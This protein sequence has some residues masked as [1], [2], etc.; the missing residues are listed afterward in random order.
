MIKL[1][2]RTIIMSLENKVWFSFLFFFFPDGNRE[3]F[4]RILK[5]FVLFFSKKITYM[6]I[7]EKN[8]DPMSLKKAVK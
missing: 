2:I 7:K 5:L 1:K 6:G 8:Q 3:Q 4:K